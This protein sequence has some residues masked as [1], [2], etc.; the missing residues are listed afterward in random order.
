MSYFY[1]TLLQLSKSPPARKCIISF[2]HVTLLSN[3]N[4]TK[5]SSHLRLEIDMPI[6]VNLTKEKE[7]WK[8]KLQEC[9]CDY[10]SER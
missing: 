8:C 9:E 4:G 3:L 2:T 6:S 1:I 5:Y 10:K 7:K